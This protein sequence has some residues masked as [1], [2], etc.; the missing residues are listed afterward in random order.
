MRDAGFSG[1]SSSIHVGRRMLEKPWQVPAQQN[2]GVGGGAGSWRRGDRDATTT[3]SFRKETAFAWAS[4]RRQGE[5]LA[6]KVP[7]LR[8]S[9]SSV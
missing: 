7:G 4:T 1:C 9:S 6:F 2:P 5:R 8:L 3:H